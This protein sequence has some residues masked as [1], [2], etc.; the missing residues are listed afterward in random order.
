M[1]VENL[2]RFLSVRARPVILDWYKNDTCIISTAI[3][4]DFC[5][6]FGETVYPLA[7]RADI[8]NK[9]MRKLIESQG[10]FPTDEQVDKWVENS[11][12]WGVGV[13]YP[14]KEGEQSPTKWPGHLIAYSGEFLLDLSIDQASRPHKGIFLE[15]PLLVKD[16]DMA[17]FISNKKHLP[18]FRNGC[19]IIYRAM[20]ED[21]SYTNSR[22]WWLEAKR[23]A[24]VDHLISQYE[25]VIH[26]PEKPDS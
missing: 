12:A 25:E 22:D 5:R 10:K 4:I 18:V 21:A 3:V 13:G 11:G 6:H 7:C 19:V 24:I 8:Y 26:E 14:S 1:A 2:L 15:R 23:K 9:P 16:K 20:P 17:E